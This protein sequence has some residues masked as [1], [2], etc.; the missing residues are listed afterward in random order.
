[1]ESSC[2]ER[3]SGDAGA[4]PVPALRKRH[5]RRPDS[6]LAWRQRGQTAA[7]IGLASTSG[8]M[9]SRRNAGLANGG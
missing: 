2:A 3:S 9:E 7:A 6:A 5:H 8:T 1:M 4:D